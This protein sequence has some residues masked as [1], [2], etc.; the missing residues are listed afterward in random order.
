MPPAIR[1]PDTY[2]YR[3]P[4]L[5]AQRDREGVS[6]PRR[7][8]VARPILGLPAVLGSVCESPTTLDPAVPARSVERHE[9]GVRRGLL[10]SD[11]FSDKLLVSIALP[12]GAQRPKSSEINVRDVH[13]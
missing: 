11:L 8:A 5:Q 2:A 6:V 7:D 9:F 12:T 13:G 4:H 3:L 1:F 10:L